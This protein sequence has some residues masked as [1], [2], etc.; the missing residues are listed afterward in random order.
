MPRGFRKDVSATEA[1]YA[2]GKL[3]DAKRRSFVSQPKAIP[4]ECDEPQPH[5]LLY[6]AD[7]SL[8]RMKLFQREKSRCQTCQLV[9]VW[10]GNSEFGEYECDGMAGEWKHIRDKPWNK[11]DCLANAEL[12]CYAHHQGPGSEHYKRRPRFGPEKV[13]M[14]A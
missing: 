5:L 11:C 13:S 7:K 3:I 4:G 14:D 10:G 9:V 2:S 12:S 8:Q 1:A 6:G